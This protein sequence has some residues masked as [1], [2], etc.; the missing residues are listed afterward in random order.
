MRDV[1]PTVVFDVLQEHL[2]TG[3]KAAAQGG[4]ESASDEEDA[5]TGDFCGRLRTGWREVLSRDGSWR[6]RIQYK[7]FRGRGTDALEKHS[8]ADGI[9]Q[10]EV[11]EASGTIITKGVLF[12]AKK[13]SGSS[14]SDLPEQARKMEDLAPGGSAVFEFGPDSYRAEA[15][16]SIL[17]VLEERPGRIP[18]PR[19][20]IADYLA[21]QF[22]TCKS[23]LRGMYYDGVR[24]ILVLPAASDNRLL[25][26]ALRHRVR[27]EVVHE[28][29]FALAEERLRR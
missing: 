3:T 4:W 26:L 16:A 7:K 20:P 6:W 23:G 11:H 17:G 24:K 29:Q 8:G 19:H 27:I 28:T 5:L 18:H 15:T 21:D 12:Q 1:I 13:V 22:L 9:V 10:I 2:R 14:R 25:P